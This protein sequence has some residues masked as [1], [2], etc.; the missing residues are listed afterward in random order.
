VSRDTRLLFVTAWPLD[1]LGGISTL[2]RSLAGALVRMAGIEVSVITGAMPHVPTVELQVP[3]PASIRLPLEAEPRPDWLPPAA[4]LVGRACLQGL[5]AAIAAVRPDVVIS[6]S[7]HS[8]EAHQAAKA[9][10][11]LGIPWI[12]WP[13]IHADAPQHVNRTAARLYRGAALVVCTSSVERRWLTEDAGLPAARTLLLECGS[14]AAEM[15]MRAVQATRPGEPVALL[16]VGE[17]AAHKRLADQVEAVAR[18]GSDGVEA[19]LTIAGVAR[20]GR[21]VAR[22]AGLVRE[23]GL[24]RRVSLLPDVPEEALAALYRSADYFLFTSASESFGLALLDAIC[25]GTFPLVYPH[26]TYA[27]LVD[28]SGFGRV[29]ARATPEALAAAVRRAVLDGEPRVGPLSAWRDAHAWP[30]VAAS[31]L[32]R[33]RG[34]L[35]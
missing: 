12:L 28:A 4:E 3:P 17:F 2:V 18:L 24:E 9:A 29:T 14:W 11:D 26:A 34:L 35:P 31:L 23:R 30:R 33:V 10:A 21:G 20:G 16:T 22:L 32:A 5:D 25:A 1:T 7:H 6:V 13:L 15:P 27:G 8:A 19:R